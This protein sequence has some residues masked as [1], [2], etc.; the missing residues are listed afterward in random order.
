LKL[1]GKSRQ[2]FP[3]NLWGVP[4]SPGIYEGVKG[5]SPGIYEGV[6]GGLV[7]DSLEIY[8]EI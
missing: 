8:N 7:G 3:R 6:P 5:E 4:E 2:G 1:T